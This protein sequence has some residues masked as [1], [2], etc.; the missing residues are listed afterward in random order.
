[1]VRFENVPLLLGLVLVITLAGAPPTKAAGPV[2]RDAE[3]FSRASFPEGFLWGT[4]TAAFQVE[5]AV[6]E[7]C[8][9]PSMWDTFTKKYP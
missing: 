7:G 6:D 2:C 3:K 9:G 4:A 8:R 5:G 1:M